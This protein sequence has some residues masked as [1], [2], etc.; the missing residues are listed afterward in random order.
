[1]RKYTAVYTIKELL[2]S[3]NFGNLNFPSSKGLNEEIGIK[4]VNRLL[5]P[6]A[7]A[8]SILTSVLQTPDPTI[9]PKS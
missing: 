7:I 9:K 1:M 6:L 8:G 4:L 3:N 2:L 5:R